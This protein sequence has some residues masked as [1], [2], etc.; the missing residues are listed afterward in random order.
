[1]LKIKNGKFYLNGSE[2]N[3]YSGA[4]HYFRVLPEYWRDRLLKLKAM[5]LNTV[6]T[7]VAWNAHEKRE[8][9]FDFSGINDV[10]AF[11]E[12]AKDL[13]LYVIV[14][15]GPYIC[16]EWDFGGFPAWL[17]KYEDLRLRTNEP[18]YMAYVKR[19]LEHLFGEIA[20]LQISR[21]GNIIAMQVENEYGSYGRDK[22][23]L[24]ELKKI[25]IEN[26]IDCLLF[27]SDGESRNNL[28][29]GSL[30][31]ELMVANF[32][33]H[34]KKKFA[35]LKEMQPNKPLVC[36]EFW[37]GWFT[38]YGGYY[39][40]GSSAG[41]VASYLKEFIEI[42]A[43][44]NFYMFHGGTNFGFTSGANCYGRYTPDIT[45]Y[46][47]GAPLTEWGE[48]TEKYHKCR[49]VLLKAQ[50]LEKEELPPSPVT[51]AYPNVM[52]DEVAELGKVIDSFAIKSHSHQIYHMEHYGQN[53]GYILYST[54][55]SG[56]YSDTKITLE[57]VHDIA[58]VFINGELKGRFN[59]L[60]VDYYK[61]GSDTF[62][63]PI[64]A[65]NGKI[66]IDILV[67][68]M[69][70]VNYGDKLYDKKGVGG[71][72]IGGQRIY[73]WTIRNMEMSN[74]PNVTYES[75][76]NAKEDISYPAFIKGR[77]KVEEKRDTFIDL[78]G[79][80][81]GTVFI[82]GFNLGRYWNIGPERTLYL[83]APLLK[84]DNEIVIFEQEKVY[85]NEILFVEKPIYGDYLPS[86]S[87]PKRLFG[88]FKLK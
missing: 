7:Y 49:E 43:G 21:G 86:N 74:A 67:E 11:I 53:Q 33:S 12:T 84:E 13:G 27:T 55:F 16:A 46:D 6:E 63:V 22:V 71:V 47:Y 26:G 83:P 10:R 4:I 61:G 51:K 54:E 41:Q 62:E 18:R 32:G 45:S 30:E 17:L 42:G 73:G 14:R 37:C 29:G 69:G 38:N 50:G 77:F 39:N 57:E 85:K 70:R 44:F 24:E 76:E 60:D 20:D 15:P 36:G 8:G 19:Y 82:N 79:F 64:K 35:E 72:K 40:P 31:N 87:T 2:F 88:W 23:Y 80:T 48:Y 9:E 65:F 3:L 28:S 75:K 66:R 56:N 5:G 34:P 58:Y 1:M 78:K 81:K 25:Y 59:R 68:A 52:L